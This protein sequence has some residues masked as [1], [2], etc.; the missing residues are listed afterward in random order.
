MIPLDELL[1]GMLKGLGW[2]LKAELETLNDAL[3]IGPKC[4]MDYSCW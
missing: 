2:L 4:S 3:E 1:I